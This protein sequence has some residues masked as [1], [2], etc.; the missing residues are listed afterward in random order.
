MTA[1]PPRF[2]SPS[3]QRGQDSR[4]EYMEFDA[5]QSDVP[6]LPCNQLDGVVYCPGT[7][8][9]KPFHRLKVEDF[10]A[11]FEVN[12]MGAVKVLQSVF[13]KLKSGSN[14]SVVLFS[15]VAVQQ[16]MSFH[17]SIAASKGSIEGLTRSLAAELAP[18]IRVNCIAPS[19]TDTPLAQRL[20]ST[21]E[22][23]VTS[24]K[25]HPLQ[26][27]GQPEDIAEMALFLLSV[28]SKWITGQVLG[29][30]G[31]MSSIKMF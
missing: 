2:R 7:I 12:V 28:K 29:V 26:N 27:V 6:D 1:C 15:T 5:M 16:G 25:R 23:K 8:N 11:D 14:P 9:L 18:S 17:S 19:V 13:S 20:L 22:K 3:R 4:V 10:R 24:S 30:D 21:E 31:G